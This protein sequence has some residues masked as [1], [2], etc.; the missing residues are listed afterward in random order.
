[1]G[2]DLSRLSPILNNRA[3]VTPPQPSIARLLA[4]LGAPTTCFTTQRQTQ[5]KA[6]FYLYANLRIVGH[7]QTSCHALNVLLAFSHIVL[8]LWK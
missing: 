6:K 4:I 3:K 7:D 5:L 2:L 8:N 1:V